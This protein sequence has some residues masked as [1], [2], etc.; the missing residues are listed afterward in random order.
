MAHA[1]LLGQRQPVLVFAVIAFEL[2][3]THGRCLQADAIE[4][5]FCCDHA[6][7]VFVET[8]LGKTLAFELHD[9]GV[10]ACEDRSQLVDCGIDILVGNLK[11]GTLRRLGYERLFDHAVHRLAAQLCQQLQLI[12]AGPYGHA[13]RIAVFDVEAVEALIAYRLT[14]DA[15]RIARIDALRQDSG[16]RRQQ[17]EQQAAPWYSHCGDS[18]GGAGMPIRLRNGRS[19]YLRFRDGA[20]TNT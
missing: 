16:P 1:H 18:A 10:I 8:L 6:A 7:D 14:I 11:T 15:Y 13:L 20:P 19:V 4:V 9:E 12:A 2:R 5:A 17:D 3:L